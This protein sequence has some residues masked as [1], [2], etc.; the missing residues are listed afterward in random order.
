M[1]KESFGLLSSGAV[2]AQREDEGA[3]GKL[4]A[5]SVSASTPLRLQTSR[6]AKVGTRSKLQRLHSVSCSSCL[7]VGR[8]QRVLAKS[9][10]GRETRV[11]EIAT[12]RER[13]GEQQLRRTAGR[14]RPRVNLPHVPLRADC[15]N[16][17]KLD[18]V[19]AHLVVACLNPLFRSL[20]REVPSPSALP[21]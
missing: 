17:V 12:A 1:K 20:V 3:R 2:P 13:R 6:R 10:S 21:L 9:E 18:S 5:G 8:A 7:P 19:S 15:T 14:C 4:A 11:P 16:R